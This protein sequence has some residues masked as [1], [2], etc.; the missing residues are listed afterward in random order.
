ME[1]IYFSRVIIYERLTLCTEEAQLSCRVVYW[2]CAFGSNH[3]FSTRSRGCGVGVTCVLLPTLN[4]LKC[5]ETCEPRA[6]VT[7]KTPYLLIRCCYYYY[8]YAQSSYRCRCSSSWSLFTGRYGMLVGREV[9]PDRNSSR[10]HTEEGSPFILHW[11][12]TRDEQS[13]AFSSVF[14]WERRCVSE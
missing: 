4:T 9:R 1:N 12:R 5:D 10:G 14:E 8:I 11:V 13:L 7:G 3:S 6:K 2:V